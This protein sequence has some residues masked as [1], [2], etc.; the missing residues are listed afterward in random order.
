MS[1]SLKNYPDPAKIFDN[2]WADAMRF[3]LMNSPV[4]EAQDLRFSEAWVEEVVK[5]VILPL[6]N[7]YSFFTTYANIDKFEPNS[8]RHPELV[9]GSIKKSATIYYCRHWETDYNAKNIM[10]WW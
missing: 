6:W 8:S 2:Y 1:K 5:K 9:S 10:N 3:Y 4:V 7:T